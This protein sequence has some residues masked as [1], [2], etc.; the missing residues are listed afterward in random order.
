MADLAERTEVAALALRFLIL[1]AARTSEVLGATV[2]EIKG[3]VWTVPAS[4]MKAGREH[5]VPLTEAA[6]DV[7]DEAARWRQEASG[8][9]FQT[10]GT[11]RPV[12]AQAPRALL[13]R[14]GYDGITVHGFR[15]AFR[16]W[17]AE[18]TGTAA[19]VI[20]MSLAHTVGNAV[21]RAY[22][23]SDLLDKRRQLAELWSA[24]LLSPSVS[25]DVVP[26]RSSR[27]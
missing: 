3:V 21:E 16:T 7:L 4:R 2:A 9:L 12:D 5:R 11:R 23:K 10:A 1:T 26:L 22:Q 20:E 25:G 15:S 8:F 6:L 19:D 17:A 18:R 13:R 14:M 27:S 24:F